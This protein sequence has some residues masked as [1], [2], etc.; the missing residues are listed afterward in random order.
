MKVLQIAVGING[1]GVGAVLLN[2]YTHM[3]H[4]DVKFD[5]IIDDLPSVKN[6]SLNEDAFK[7]MGCNIF[8]VTPKSQNLSENIRQVSEIMKNGNYDILHS[9]MEEWSALYCKLGKKYG[10]KTRI[11]HAHLAYV[12]NPSFVKRMYNSVLKVGLRRYATDF[13]ACSKD[14]GRYLFGDKILEKNNFRVLPNAIDTKSYSYNPST[15]KRIRNEFGIAD[16][17]FAVG[18][19]GRLYYQKNP[20]RMLSIFNEICKLHPDSHLVIVGDYKSYAKFDGL[21]KYAEENGFSDKITYTGLRKDVPNVMQAFDAFVL[22]SRYEGFGI[23]YIEAQAAGLMTF[24]TAKVVLRRLTAHR[25]CTLLILSQRINSGQSKFLKT[26][27][28]T[29][30]KIWLRK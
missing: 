25:L 21:K 1:G 15:R 3:N 9:N 2:F 17:T 19:V 14:A 27:L 8:R 22:P 5:I 18:F 6:G 7:K 26:A 29:S 12:N 23:V 24:G 20:E 11:A 10:I 30:E 13:F 16:T 4:N 28:T